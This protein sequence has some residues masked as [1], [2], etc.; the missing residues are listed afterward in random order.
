MTGVPVHR[1][2]VRVQN[3]KVCACVCAFLHMAVIGNILLLVTS[4]EDY[5]PLCLEILIILS[6]NY[7]L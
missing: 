5:V 6:V 7:K 2:V 4:S 1:F 3:H